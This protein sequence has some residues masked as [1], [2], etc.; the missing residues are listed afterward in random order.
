MKNVLSVSLVSCLWLLVSPTTQAIVDVNDND[1]SDLWEKAHNDGNL[2]PVTFDPQADTDGDGWTNAQEAA[3]GTDPSDANPPTGYLQPEITHYPAVYHTDPE[4]NITATQSPATVT[5][6]WPT[7]PGKQYTLHYSTDLAPG[8]W[9]PLGAPRI[10]TGW[11]MGNGITLTQQDGSI[12]DRIFWRVAVTDPVPA[13]DTDSD[14]LGDYEEYLAGTDPVI[15]DSD[16][17]HLSDYAELIAGTNPNHADEDGD[18][19]TDPLE[20]AAGTNSKNQDT[21]GDAIPDW[22]DSQPLLS[23]QIFADADNDGIPDANDPDP[24]NPRGSK[25]LIISDN[26]SGNPHCELEMDESSSF[27]L[28]VSNPAGP[29]PTSSDFTLYLNGIEETATITA[30]STPSSAIG[31]QR[32]NFSWLAK[33]T[34]SYPAQTLQNI[35][36]RFRDSQNATTWLNVARADVAEWEGMI[37]AVSGGAP[38]YNNSPMVCVVSHHRGIKQ[39]PERLDGVGSVWYRGPKEIPLLDLLSGSDTGVT[40]RIETERY[41]LFVIST[42]GS[43]RVVERTVDV[44]DPVAY[45]HHGIFYL[46][47][48]SSAVTMSHS[49][50]G[51]AVIPAGGFQ[52]QPLPPAPEY[53]SSDFGI[54]GNTFF[55]GEDRLFYSSVWGL[56][57]DH[58]YFRNFRSVGI[59]NLPDLEGEPRPKLS[60][61]GGVIAYIGAT[62][63]PH[64]AGTLECPGMP[65]SPPGFPPAPYSHY[66]YRTPLL[67]IQSEQWHKLVLKVGPD[68]GALSNGITLKIGTGAEGENDPQTGF[69]LQTPG[70]GGFEPLT[71]PANGKIE[72]AP[73][74]ELYQKL[75]SLEG[76]TLFLN[77]DS[78]VN[79]FHRLGLDLIPKRSTYLIQRVAAVDLPPLDLVPDI[80]MAGVIGDVVESAVVG[81]NIKHFVTPKL[82][83]ELP[84]EYVI[85]KTTGV[86]AE[87]ITDGS[88]KQIVEW[89][90]GEAVPSE[91]LKRRVKR[92]TP[93]SHPVKIKAKQGGEVAVQMNVWVVW[94]TLEAID[95]TPKMQN[96]VDTGTSLRL[97]GEIRFR[98][99]CEPTKMF[100]LKSD[101]PALNVP[102][103]TAPPGTN[104]PWKNTPLAFGAE[105]KIDASRQFRVLSKSNDANTHAALHAA[106]PDIAVYP[107]NP[108]EGND[109]PSILG[110]L[111]PYLPLGITAKMADFDTPFVEIPHTRGSETPQATISEL[112]QFRQFS[113][114]EIGNRWYKISDFFLSEIYFRAK[115]EN[116][117]WVDNASTFVLGNGQFP[118]P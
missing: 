10:G 1:F 96:P 47:R 60:G 88:A 93:A 15:T 100:D 3:A 72:M 94:C 26:A 102:W 99:T 30:L 70:T 24:N 106:G 38:E 82:T 101:V 91:P 87:Q 20:L 48:W 59:A 49:P 81:S 57:Q 112:A 42:S 21:D 40:A 11:D 83:T 2:F 16:G 103:D 5:L 41:P 97:V 46:N 98:Y 78:T 118:P 55:D 62:I 52:F 29:A 33:V 92:N 85:L 53:G 22:L 45:P 104:H 12:A 17:D 71:I 114:A 44:S 116:G 6:N 32:F 19:I 56:K 109:D 50:G 90:G 65:V 76:L 95:D 73:T 35:S 18:G 31:T 63:T 66:T 115:R 14:D 36:L 37:A 79:Q 54:E 13:I 43:T 58:G 23:A 108:A 61:L 74:S 8:N 39:A 4:T 28:T 107:Q 69:T 80:N 7:L 89:D 68:A 27:I 110:E 113:R 25:P 86:T 51:T 111:R 34:T 75:T 67:P 9:S 64:S 105:I 84:Q 117:K 77:R